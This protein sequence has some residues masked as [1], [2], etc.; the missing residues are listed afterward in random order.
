MPSLAQLIRNFDANPNLVTLR[1]IANEV[2]RSGRMEDELLATR[3][4][5]ARTRGNQA[6]NALNQLR[7]RT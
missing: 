4:R 1:K 5:A 2:E 6:L 7:A 3:L